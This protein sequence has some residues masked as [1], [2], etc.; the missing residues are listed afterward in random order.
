MAVELA[1]VGA[2]VVASPGS[3]PAAL[4]RP[5]RDAGSGTGVAAGTIGGGGW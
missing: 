2:L 1:G 3:I 4:N 5:R